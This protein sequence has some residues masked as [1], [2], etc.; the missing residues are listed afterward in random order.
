MW[1][2]NTGCRSATYLTPGWKVFLNTRQ[3]KT[4]PKPS[5]R[6]GSATSNDPNTFLELPYLSKSGA[7]RFGYD[8]KFDGLTATGKAL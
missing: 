6:A 8:A 4:A 7:E 2:K 3:K 5:V 1:K